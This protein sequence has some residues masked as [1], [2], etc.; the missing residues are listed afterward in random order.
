VYG[1]K[2][3]QFGIKIKIFPQG[4]GAV[5]SLGGL[6]PNTVLSSKQNPIITISG[7]IKSFWKVLDSEGYIRNWN[8]DISPVVHQ[9]DHFQDE[10]IEIVDQFNLSQHNH[11]PIN[12]D[13]AWQAL[14]V[15]RCIW[16]CQN[17]Q[18]FTLP[19]TD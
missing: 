18:N 2:L 4:E 19:K 8:G 13:R 16:G 5:N 7:Q 6:R 11:W 12:K 17:S 1:N 3:R 15:T 14:N 10:L 9:L